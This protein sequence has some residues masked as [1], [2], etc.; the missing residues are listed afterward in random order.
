MTCYIFIGLN[1]W[2]KNVVLIF[3]C[4]SKSSTMIA[5]WYSVGHIYEAFSYMWFVMCLYVAPFRISDI[6]VLLFIYELKAYLRANN[7]EPSVENCYF[8]WSCRIGFKW[9]LSALLLRQQMFSQMWRADGRTNS[10]CL[11]YTL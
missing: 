4:Y 11:L 6:H 10:R 2:I 8:R 5:N 9:R 1:N 3:R 7:L